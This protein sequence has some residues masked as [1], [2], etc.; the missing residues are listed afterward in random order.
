M[1]RILWVHENVIRVDFNKKANNPFS[2]LSERNME[3]PRRVEF[4]NA[5]CSLN[6]NVVKALLG[7]PPKI[8]RAGIGKDDPSP[9]NVLVSLLS[10]KPGEPP[11]ELSA[12]RVRI[13]HF[14]NLILDAGADPTPLREVVLPDATTLPELLLLQGV[15]RRAGL[16]K[17][18]SP[19]F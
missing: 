10:A 8:E 7:E 18:S 17:E 12:R 5:L 4:Y 14:L 9:L 1:S 13:Y 6:F 19:P 2:P 11:Q 16:L 15:K 3:R